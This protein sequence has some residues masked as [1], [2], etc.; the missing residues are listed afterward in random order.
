MASLELVTRLRSG[1]DAVA[2]AASR[3]RQAADRAAELAREAAELA[4]RFAAAGSEIGDAAA[5]VG[6]VAGVTDLVALNAD[7]D[8]V[9]GRER[10]ADTGVGVTAATGAEQALAA[11]RLV[12]ET[13]QATQAIA[14]WAHTMRQ[15]ASAML[16][17]LDSIASEVSA[18]ARDQ[19]ALADLT[20]TQIEMT[21]DLAHRIQTACQTQLDFTA[22][23]LSA[24][25]EA[26]RH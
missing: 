13:G 1:G 15:E 23:R 26:H 8:A 18:I 20:A 21:E 5:F 9:A 12:R 10:A 17:T 24:A 2:V 11:R 22:G 16:P 3:S 19:A 6:G 14:G 25:A 7:I 4:R